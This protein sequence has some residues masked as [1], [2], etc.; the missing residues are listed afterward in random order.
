MPSEVPSTPLPIAAI[1]GA[2]AVLVSAHRRV[3]PGA[4]GDRATP[5]PLLQTDTHGGHHWPC[6][7]QVPYPTW[8]DTWGGSQP[9]AVLCL[10]GRF[11]QHFLEHLPRPA[12]PQQRFA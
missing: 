8:A 3:S 4:R 11:R 10:W 7:A 9:R 12:N 1:G 6:S 2:D 5:S